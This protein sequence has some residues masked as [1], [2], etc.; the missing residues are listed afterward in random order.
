MTQT[1]SFLVGIVALLMM[2]FGAIALTVPAY[3]QF[4]AGS[5][6]GALDAAVDDTSLAP[7]DADSQIFNI[8]GRLI[9][10]ALGLL[11]IVFFIY[12]VWAGFIWMTAGG[13]ETKTKKA[14]QMITQGTIGLVIILAAYAISS[15]AVS[16]LL[17][18][19]QAP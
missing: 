5:P 6:T 9:N 13:D 17:T 10:I 12:I 3:A 8:I 15:F 16:Q 18:A 4:E 2:V 14:T 11:G 19:T 7:G 1:K